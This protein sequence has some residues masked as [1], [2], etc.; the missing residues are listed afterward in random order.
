MK[1]LYKLRLLVLGVVF[2]LNSL[3]AQLSRAYVA[4]YA[5]MVGYATLKRL[6]I[7]TDSMPS[8]TPKRWAVFI[9]YLELDKRIEAL[10]A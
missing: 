8:V 5:D 1:N 7:I 2:L 6:R 4:V 10:N 3:V 9:C